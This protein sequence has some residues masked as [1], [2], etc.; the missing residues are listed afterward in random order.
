MP[1]PVINVTTLSYDLK[2]VTLESEYVGSV[3]NVSAFC[4][5]PST[6][7]GYNN[8]FFSTWYLSAA[9]ISFVLLVSNGTLS[10]EEGIFAMATLS[11]ARIYNID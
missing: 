4:S 9:T 11:G 2:Y 6:I 8:V 3:S 7:S 1:S 10:I 5:N